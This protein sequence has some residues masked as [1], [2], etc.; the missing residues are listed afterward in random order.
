MV[1]GFDISSEA[2]AYAKQSYRLPQLHFSIG[3]AN[4]IPIADQSVDVVACLEAIEH[5]SDYLGLLS[6][7]QRV[8]RP[9]GWVFISTPN[10][11]LQSPGKGK[12]DQP[13]NEY[14]VREFTYQEIIDILG[15][16]FQQVHVEGQRFVP[17]LVMLPFLVRIR[18]LRD[19]YRWP[20][21]IGRLSPFYE[22][23]YFIAIC[24]APKPPVS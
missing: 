21:H 3:D 2:I 20:P 14:H 15:A 22:P 8:V 9:D 24:S 4:H 10:R 11:R 5:L 12:E 23:H 18:R 16:Y 6:E 1:L 17:K 19:P 13:L 7:I